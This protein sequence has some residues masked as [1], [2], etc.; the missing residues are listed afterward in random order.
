[1]TPF[2]KE[3]PN[4]DED[5]IL[6]V[7]HVN[8][9][10]TTYRRNERENHI[11]VYRKEEWLKVLIHELLHAYRVD[12][13]A[14]NNKSIL[15]SIFPIKSE[16]NYNEAYTECWA[17]ILH[18]LLDAYIKCDTY[19][20]FRNMF[21]ENIEL[22]I[23]FS[24][25]QANKVLHH[26]Y[27]HYNALITEHKHDINISMIRNLYF[28]EDTNIFSYYVLKVVLLFFYD[29][30]IGFCGKYNM[31]YVYLQ[32]AKRLLKFIEARYKNPIFIDSVYD[33]SMYHK[34]NKDDRTLRMS[35]LKI[36][37]LK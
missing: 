17:I 14:H 30:F 6:G 26:M 31:N 37:E 19:E 11:I 13:L 2:K 34:G 16:L 21:H 20:K 24:M 5:Y 4:R 12:I 10:M 27:L 22:E 1:M 9:G 7:Q 29:E 3:L 23:C 36:I 18:C 33:Y 35:I 15:K 8:S 25:K 32:S 28:K